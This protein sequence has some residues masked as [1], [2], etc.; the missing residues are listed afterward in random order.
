MGLARAVAASF[1]GIQLYEGVDPAGAASALASLEQL[2][3][4]LTALESLG[5]VAQRA[6]RH[7]LRR[8]T[9]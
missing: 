2:T 1:V 7:H 9:R 6:I 5:P 4:L 3:A 8:T